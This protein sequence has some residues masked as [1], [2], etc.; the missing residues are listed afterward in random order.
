MNMYYVFIKI[1]TKIYVPAS[2]LVGNVTETYLTLFSFLS[3]HNTLY[4]VSKQLLIAN[5]LPSS[6]DTKYT[7]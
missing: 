7:G 3:K 6:R 1:S 5:L 4:T 2:I